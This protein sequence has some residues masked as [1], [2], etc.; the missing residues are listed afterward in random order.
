MAMEDLGS[1]MVVCALKRIS[2]VMGFRIALMGQMSYIVTITVITTTTT[3]TTITCQMLPHRQL[4]LTSLNTW[5]CD[6]L[7]LKVN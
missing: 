7:E 3:T 4:N 6:Q 1:V 2:G 5:W